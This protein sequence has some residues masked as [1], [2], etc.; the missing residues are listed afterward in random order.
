MT[1]LIT[2]QTREETYA[3]VTMTDGKQTV[4]VGKGSSGA[5]SVLNMNAAHKAYRG[6]GRTFWS[7][8]AAEE[9]YKS[10]FMKTAINLAQA[11]L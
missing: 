11:Y 10:A 5:I 8:D 2:E 1:I 7:F 4:F 9:A 3:S 6:G